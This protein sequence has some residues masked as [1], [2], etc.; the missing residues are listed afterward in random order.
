MGRRTA[1]AI[2]GLT[3]I[4]GIVSSAQTYKILHNFGGLVDGSQP[5]TGLAFDNG[6]N[7]YGTAVLGPG[8]LCQGQGCGLVF[9]MS[10]QLDGSWIE[11]VIHYFNGSDGAFPYA[12]VAF[13]SGGNIYS[14]TSQFGS[15]G[16]GTLFELKPGSNGVWTLS[17]LHDFSGGWD[18]AFPVA[19]VTLGSSGDIYST[20]QSGGMHYFGTAFSLRGEV[21]GWQEIVLHAFA[22]G[23]DGQYSYGA[24]TQ[25][26]D[27]NLYGTTFYGG[28]NHAGVVFKL[29]RNRTTARWTE[30]VLHSFTGTSGGSGLDGANPVAGVILDDAGNLYG[31]TAYGG[32]AGFGTVFKLAP[33]SDGSWN[34]SII[35]SFSGRDGAEP[36]GS[37]MF[38]SQ[39]NLYGTTAY[40][41]TSGGAWG[42]V[43]KLTSSS[44]Q[45]VETV[46]YSFSGTLDGGLPACGLVSDSAGNLYGTAILG[47]QY[48]G[49]VAFEIVP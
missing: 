41:G 27:G 8:H 19:G 14:T 35:H 34:E 7:L 13:D 29:T 18:G 5:G 32:P 2:S 15:Y 17:V 43:F 38:D 9:K 21:D 47:G 39:G 3:L 40:G 31:T 46:L 37:L 12:P 6:G 25:D 24:L 16:Y 49:G 26:A 45:W 1:L 42:T 23:D 33:Q 10:P 22:S 28:S 11:S 30:T 44:G 20:T 36:Y 4:C 48:S